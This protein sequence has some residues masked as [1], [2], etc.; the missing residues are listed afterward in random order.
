MSDRNVPMPV[1]MFERPL[2]AY[3]ATGYERYELDAEL[4][5]TLKDDDAD[6]AAGRVTEI[7]RT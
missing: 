2:R 3:R 6:D 4:A 5:T 7:V 1:R